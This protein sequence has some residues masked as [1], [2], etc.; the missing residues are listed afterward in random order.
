MKGSSIALSNCIHV[1]CAVQLK[2]PPAE[3]DAK[4]ECTHVQITPSC[5][6]VLHFPLIFLHMALGFGSPENSLFEF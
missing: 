4:Q 3:R 1:M 2:L 6:V 5:N